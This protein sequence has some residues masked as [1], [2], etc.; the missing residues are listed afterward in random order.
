MMD[1]REYEERY[2]EEVGTCNIHKAQI[3]DRSCPQCEDEEHECQFH[4]ACCD[5]PPAAGM[6]ETGRCGRCGD[7]TEFGCECGELEERANTIR[8]VK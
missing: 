4:S 7:P 5:S 6:Y 3:L 2:G 1:R 8:G